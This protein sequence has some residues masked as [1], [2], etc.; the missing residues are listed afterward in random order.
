M[1]KRKIQNKVK[2]LKTFV[3]DNTFTETEEKLIIDV[4]DDLICAIL[5]G[6]FTGK[7]EDYG[8]KNGRS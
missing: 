1:G 4:V 2:D 6:I 3:R 5:S 7:V 8:E